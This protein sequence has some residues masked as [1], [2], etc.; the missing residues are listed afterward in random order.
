MRPQAEQAFCL[1]PLGLLIFL[2]AC[3][4][5]SVSLDKFEKLHLGLNLKF[6]FGEGVP[7]QFRRAGKFLSSDRGE[8]AAT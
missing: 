6:E 1:P 4:F 5:F 7:R 3:P 2:V 8:R